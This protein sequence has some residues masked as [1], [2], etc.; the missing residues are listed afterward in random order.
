MAASELLEYD[1]PIFILMGEYWRKGKLPYDPYYYGDI[2]GVRPF[3]LYP[4]NILLSLFMERGKIDFSF[5]L[6]V[7]YVFAHILIMSFLA[8]NLFGKGLIGIFG[9]LA[10]T[11]MGYHQQQSI[12]RTAGFMW[13]TAV[14]LGLKLHQPILAGISLGMM[15]LIANPPYTLYLIYFMGL[16]WIYRLLF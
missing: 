2:V 13:L 16:F 10:W 5:R 12:T 3:V 6:L 14:L 9:A 1:F 7:Y 15:I 8:Y 11:Y 4:F